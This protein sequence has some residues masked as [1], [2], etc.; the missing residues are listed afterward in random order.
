VRAFICGDQGLRTS[1]ALGLGVWFG[2]LAGLA[3]GVHLLAWYLIERH[4]SREFDW[5]FI[6]MAAPAAVV[7]FT[8]VVCLVLGVSMFIPKGTH[9]HSR[10]GPHVFA[11]VLSFLALYSVLGAPR[12]RLAPLAVLLACAGLAS[13]IARTVAAGPDRF[14]SLVRRSALPIA[15]LVVGSIVL[16]VWHL[17]SVTER[18]TLAGL[19]SPGDGLPNIILIILDTVRAKSLSL[20]GYDK[21]TSPNL[22][23]WASA[24]VTFEQAFSTAPW[25][26]PAHA[27]L[28]T[29]RWAHEHSAGHGT[30]LDDTYETLA[31][32]LGGLG[33]H[34]AG[35]T[36]NRTNAAAAAGLARGFAR[37]EDYVIGWGPFL[38]RSFVTRTLLRFLPF[39]KSEWR[40]AG[41]N[42]E[43]NTNDV[44]RWLP[45]ERDRPLFVFVNYFDAHDPYPAPSQY[46][47]RFPSDI[48]PFAWQ[49]PEGINEATA[50]GLRAQYDA[51]ISY[52]DDEVDRF[53]KELEGQ[54]VLDNAIVV[55]SSDHGEAMGEHGLIYHGNH[56]YTPVIQVPLVLWAPGRVPDGHRLQGPVSI[57]DIGATLLN[58]ATGADQ[59]FSGHS[60]VS[61]WEDPTTPVTG[62]AVVAEMGPSWQT[63]WLDGILRS[64]ISGEHQYMRYPEGKEEL[65]Q[66]TGPQ[67][68]QAQAP[69]LLTQ[70]R[71]RLDS[72]LN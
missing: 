19:A 60:L 21:P 47:D 62:T 53:L 18:R 61:Q 54:G 42:A 28:F 26:L 43:Q 44:L 71:A 52:V 8:V 35:F 32:R 22:E 7:G 50:A 3:E 6:W 48:A 11:F 20:Y 41:K 27:S 69:L 49:G 66:A 30:V 10:P 51:A 25:T 58:L 67:T 68:T 31:E 9:E 37:Y 29:G 1:S 36:A 33:Y 40:L 16:G 46:R 56:L 70:Y 38:T 12:L 34:T 57:R 45:Q 39:D 23:R 14:Q 5:E 59:D 2:C 15:G 17:P 13:V 64:V 55:I 63:P 4:P 72:I 65:Y 24:G